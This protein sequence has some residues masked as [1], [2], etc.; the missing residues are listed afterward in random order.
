[1]GNKIQRIDNVLHGTRVDIPINTKGLGRTIFEKM[2]QYRDK[3]LQ[4]DPETG[5]HQTYENVN[6]KCIR[7][8]LA[9]KSR[10]IQTGDIIVICLENSMESLV[11]TYAILFDRAN[12]EFL[13]KNS[14][15]QLE[16]TPKIIVTGTHRTFGT[17]I[18]YL[19]PHPEE[20]TFVPNCVGN[21]QTTAII[22]CSSGTTGLPKA[23]SFSHD[24]IL[25]SCIA[26]SLN[27]VDSTTCLHYTS[28]HHV[29][30]FLWTAVGI[31]LGGKRI[32]GGTFST[33][34]FLKY[35]EE[36]KCPDFILCHS[37]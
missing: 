25:R 20:Q 5:E 10:G 17:L 3:I 28:V 13:I 26:M 21:L 23:L 8:A 27:V 36:Y 35:V 7:L 31:F 1:M 14:L 16:I 24:A 22:F 6:K 32:I 2:K 18:E 15:A 33:A 4:I 11:L 37:I 29:I 12:Q 9:L 30:A 19:K 34:K